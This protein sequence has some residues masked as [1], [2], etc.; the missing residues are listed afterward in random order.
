MY[1]SLSMVLL[2]YKKEDN[3]QDSTMKHIS[4]I[5]ENKAKFVKIEPSIYI[6]VWLFSSI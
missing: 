3:N 6:A 2:L 4:E 5:N 1:Q